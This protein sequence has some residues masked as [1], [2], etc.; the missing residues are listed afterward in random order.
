MAETVFFEELDVKVT[1]ARLN[2]GSQMFSLNNITS[3]DIT[4]DRRTGL[5]L[6][7]L[8]FAVAGIGGLLSNINARDTGTAIGMIIAGIIMLAMPSEYHVLLK[9]EENEVKV[10]KHTNKNYIKKIINA[11]NEAMAHVDN[12]VVDD[13]TKNTQFQ[14]LTEEK[15]KKEKIISTLISDELKKLAELRDAGILSDAE[16]QQQKEKL[17]AKG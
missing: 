4:E 10:F 3:V 11:I 6:L 1:N 8:I 14:N 16:F 12:K 5:H 13:E 7:G 2:I 9:T 15:N 17:L